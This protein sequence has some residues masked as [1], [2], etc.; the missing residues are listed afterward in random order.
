M[1]QSAPASNLAALQ[2][3]LTSVDPPTPNVYF[4]FAG[5]LDTKAVQQFFNA[6]A[7][8]KVRLKA[9]HVH[10][11]FHTPGGRV[12]DGVCLYHFFKSVPFELTIY[13]A[14]TVQSMG[15]VA[16][17]GAK[18]RKVSAHGTFMIHRIR[19]KSEF[20]TASELKTV[21]ESCNIDDERTGSILKENTQFSDEQMT[22]FNNR[23]LI[24]DAEAAVKACVVNEIRD[25][26][27]PADARIYSITAM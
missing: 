1:T 14:G 7:Y 5:D 23:D 24:I 6:F 10:L 3:L 26:A 8:A 17:L 20:A 18:N 4:A 25:F 2:D 16:F 27:P 9:S 19:H 12:D 11:L 22:V 21:V 15:V 13:N